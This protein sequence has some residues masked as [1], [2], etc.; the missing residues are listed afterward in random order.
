MEQSP[1]PD[2]VEAIAE[3]KETEP[4][5]LNLALYEYIDPEAIH[6]LASHGTASW[7]LTFELPEHE[8][9]VTS[10]GGIFVDGTQ[11]GLWA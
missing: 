7:T 2:I 11:E 8:V 6:R 1:V 4:S 3:A 10:D 5:K 9:T